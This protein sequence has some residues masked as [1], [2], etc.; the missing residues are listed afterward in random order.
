MKNRKKFLPV[1]DNGKRQNF[2]PDGAGVCKCGQPGQYDHSC[3]YA[4]DIGNDSETQCNC[5]SSCQ[6]ACA[7]DI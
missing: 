2:D 3:P 1:I 5:C 4:S 7:E 6:T